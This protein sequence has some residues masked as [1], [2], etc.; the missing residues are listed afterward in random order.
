MPMTLDEIARACAAPGPH[1]WPPHELEAPALCCR[2]TFHPL[3]FPT[4]LRTNSAGI[5]AQ[6]RDLWGSFEERFDTRPIR[7]DVHVAEGGP[8]P[9]PPMPGIR[10]ALPLMIAVADQDHY[11]VADLEAARTQ[12]ML[13]RAAEQH[14]GYVGYC[15]LEFAALCHIGVRHSTPVHGA[16]V[17]LD[18]R[19]VLLCGDSGAGKSSLSYACARAGWTYVTDDASYLLHHAPDRRVV[20]H[21]RKIRFRP[22]AADLFPELKGLDLTPRA[23]GK[24]SMEVATAALPGLTCAPSARI[25]AVVFLN[26]RAGGAPGLAPLPKEVARQYLRQV[27]YGPAPAREVQHLAI[28]RL[29]TADVLEL[30]YQD[31]DR[32]V[33]CLETLLRTG[34]CEAGRW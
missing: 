23:A 8:E 5:L 10:I 19:G 11:S 1:Q 28:E 2:E 12:V 9:C 13:T 3:G 34:P 6:A 17:A 32:A 14:R 30:R 15:F 33:R 16:C 21:C 29:L 31:L 7:V 22:S 26:R 24:P 25:D 4:E 27:L 18:G 20:G